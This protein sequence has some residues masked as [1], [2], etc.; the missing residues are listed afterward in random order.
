MKDGAIRY[1]KV[2]EGID[3]ACDQEALRVVQAMPK[4]RPG[5]A[6]KLPVNVRVELPIVFMLSAQQLH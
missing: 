6:N 1:A 4:W 5:K 3:P 2:E